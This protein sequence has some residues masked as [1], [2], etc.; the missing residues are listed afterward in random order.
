MKRV[1]FIAV[2]IIF[3]A[4]CSKEDVMQGK[5]TASTSIGTINLELLAGGNCVASLE[6]GEEDTGTYDIDG[7]EII[8]RGARVR[9]GSIGSS[10]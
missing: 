1:L 2:A 3:L 5:Y 6:G 9:K 10:R 4:G 7:K 8:V